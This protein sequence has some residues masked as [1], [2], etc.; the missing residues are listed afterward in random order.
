VVHIH[1]CCALHMDLVV[2]MDLSLHKFY[3]VSD[4]L[5]PQQYLQSVEIIVCLCVSVCLCVCVCVCVCK[6]VS[7]CVCV[8]VYMCIYVCVCVCVS[9]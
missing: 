5:S 6:C 2:M 1:R 7:V 8:C 4:T 3:D 9:V